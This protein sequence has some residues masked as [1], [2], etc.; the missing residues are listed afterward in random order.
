MKVVSYSLL[1]RAKKH[2]WSQLKTSG[3]SYTSILSLVRIILQT[4]DKVFNY[5]T[6]NPR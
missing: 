5:I 4:Q 3:I 2:R 1:I 6:V